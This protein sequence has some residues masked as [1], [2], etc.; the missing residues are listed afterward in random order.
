MILNADYIQQFKTKYKRSLSSGFVFLV[1]S[2][3]RKSKE[4]RILVHIFK[5]VSVLEFE[6]DSVLKAHSLGLRDLLLTWTYNKQ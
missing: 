4:E 6:V 5:K 1:L 2:R 3:M